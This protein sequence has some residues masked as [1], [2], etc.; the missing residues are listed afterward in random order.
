[1]PEKARWSYTYLYMGGGWS[2]TYR[3]L[4]AHYYGISQRKRHIYLIADFAGGSVRKILFESK[5]SN[6]GIL[7]K[8]SAHSN[9]IP[10]VLELA[11]ELHV[12]K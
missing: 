10:N 4:D 1:M 6:L 8:V 2:I 9:G 12:P 3:T 7:C 11:L 5:S